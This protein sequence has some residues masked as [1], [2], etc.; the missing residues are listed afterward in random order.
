[1]SRLTEA[2]AALWAGDA[3]LLIDEARDAA[4]AL[5]AAVIAPYLL[6]AHART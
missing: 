1:M 4:A 5:V 3:I 2:T 6:A